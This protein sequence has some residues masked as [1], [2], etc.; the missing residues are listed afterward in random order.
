MITT[1][2]EA[3]AAAAAQG[4]SINWC[5]YDEGDPWRDQWMKGWQAE[6]EKGRPLGSS[7]SSPQNKRQ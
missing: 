4:R 1:V 3:G 6:M 7:N 2:E 5:P